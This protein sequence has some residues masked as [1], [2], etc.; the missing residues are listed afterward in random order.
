[1]KLVNSLTA[2]TWSEPLDIHGIPM[3]GVPEKQGYSFSRAGWM[4]VRDGEAQ[5]ADFAGL[6]VRRVMR[7]L[8]KPTLAQARQEYADKTVVPYPHYFI[9]EPTGFCNKACPFCSIHVIERK[10]EHGKRTSL[11]MRWRDFHKLM[12]EIGTV[13]QSYGLS[14]YG[15]GESMLWR[16]GTQSI[17]DMISA[18]K[19]IGKFRVVNLSTNGDVNN[20]NRLLHTDLD[21]LIISIDGRTEKTYLANRPSTKADDPDA[22]ARTMGRVAEFCAEKARRG[23]S[24]PFVRLQIIN[25]ADTAPEIVDFIKLWIDTPGVDDVFVKHLDAMTPWLGENVVSR[26]EADLKMAAVKAMPCQHLWA[27]GWM[28]AAGSFTA[29]CHDARAELTMANADGTWPSIR[30]GTFNEWWTGQYMTGLRADHMGGAIDFAPCMT[31]HE[32]DPWLG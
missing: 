22:F 15:L 11:M 13:G 5:D 19:S 9:I 29:C 28:N 17:V 4:A 3:M 7:P 26:A 30:T 14:L 10:D 27:V 24:K 32:R 2:F 25:K 12:I 31:C 21:D 16:E 20:L 1:M 6:M 23:L 8:S 18:A